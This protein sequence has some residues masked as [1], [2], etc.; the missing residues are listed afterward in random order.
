MSLNIFNTFLRGEF[1]L[2]GRYGLK[3][4]YGD[5]GLKGERGP[6]AEWA[7]PGEEGKDQVVL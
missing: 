6:A 2:D 1:G 7:E 5:R 4:L 3:G